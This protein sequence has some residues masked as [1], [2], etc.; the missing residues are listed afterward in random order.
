MHVYCAAAATFLTI[1]SLLQ[2]TLGDMGCAYEG[3][4]YFPKSEGIELLRRMGSGY[5]QGPTVVGRNVDESISF[6]NT[7]V[8]RDNPKT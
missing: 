2:P 1:L 5:T 7:K 3:W 4:R 8:G 6:G